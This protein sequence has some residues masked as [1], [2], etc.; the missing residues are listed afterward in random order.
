MWWRLCKPVAF[1]LVILTVT[2]LNLDLQKPGGLVLTLL[3]DGAV[4]SE[5]SRPTWKGGCLP[6]N[7]F[8]TGHRTVSANVVW[9]ANYLSFRMV[10]SVMQQPTG[11]ACFLKSSFSCSTPLGKPLYGWMFLVGIFRETWM[12]LV[13]FVLKKLMVFNFHAKLSKRAGAT[14]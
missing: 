13:T 1:L 7:W 8:A 9:P 11:S 3:A 2:R 10:T 6:I 14:G 12:F 5:L 4:L